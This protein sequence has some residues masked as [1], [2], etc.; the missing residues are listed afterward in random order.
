MSTETAI[1]KADLMLAPLEEGSPVPASHYPLL[2]MIRELREELAALLAQ[3][4]MAW[5]YWHRDDPDDS[6][7]VTTTRWAPGTLH[8][9]WQET[10]LYAAPAP[11]AVPPDVYELASNT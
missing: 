11:A 10:K 9:N 3:E 1:H 8:P 4:P 5:A 2:L 6:L 7:V